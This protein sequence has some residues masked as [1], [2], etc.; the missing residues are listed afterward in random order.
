MNKP[1]V[2]LNWAYY[3]D[4]WI[5]PFERMKNEFNF[6][7]ISYANSSNKKEGFPFDQ[8]FWNDY[9]SAIELIEKIKP[10]KIVFMSIDSGYSIA[11]NAVAK[12]RGIK[13]IVLQHGLF[14]DYS[15]Y[16][17][18]EI[19]NKNHGISKSDPAFVTKK[20][21]TIQFIVRSVSLSPFK[22]F[23]I[24]LYLIFARL[25]GVN[26]TLMNLNISTFKA[27]EYFCYT[28]FNGRVYIQ[29]DQVKNE[30]IIEIGNP[31]YDSFFFKKYKVSKTSEKYYLLID[32]P[33]A[34]NPFNNFGVTRDDMNRFYM[35]LNVFCKKNDA[36]LIIKLHPE[37][38]SSDFLI[39]DQNIQYV[40]KGNIEELVL[41][42]EG[43]FG[44]FS[45][46]II[47]AIYF[48][49][50]ILFKLPELISETQEDL[51]NLGVVGSL[52]FFEFNP[53]DILFSSLDVSKRHSKEFIQKYLYKA[54]GKSI[55][56]LSNSLKN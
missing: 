13:T 52:D 41:N 23:S 2:L 51:I 8:L 18:M 28:R 50:C 49:P 4:D 19:R 47:P 55:K 12:S 40:R 42:S 35:K 1:I 26:W 7:F 24:S 6:K 53:A 10:E 44:T 43:S 17:K 20:S 34:E 30:Q 5:T 56:R 45:N 36:K 15:F 33:F 27:N 46:L 9:N 22:L 38:Y 48:K 31:A 3:R 32:Q 21:H 16:R 39:E 54:D 37:S 25:K 29:R 14:H 11:L